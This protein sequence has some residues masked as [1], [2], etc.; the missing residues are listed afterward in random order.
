MER[1]INSILD[2]LRQVTQPI[3]FLM[4]VFIITVMIRLI[5]EEWRNK[6]FDENKF[7]KKYLLAHGRACSFALIYSCVLYF[8]PECYF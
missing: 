3:L 8:I 5:Q 4:V 7:G 1:L 2:Y 6:D